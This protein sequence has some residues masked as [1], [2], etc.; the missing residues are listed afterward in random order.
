MVFVR[1]NWLIPIRKR[2]GFDF[3]SRGACWLIMPGSGCA[4][5]QVEMLIQI[6]CR[7]DSVRDVFR[8]FRFGEVKSQATTTLDFSILITGLAWLGSI[9][10]SKHPSC[11]LCRRVSVVKSSQA[12]KTKRPAARGGQAFG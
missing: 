11:S 2:W 5:Q 12:L 8:L 1:T 10:F 7:R 6:L 9:P 4:F 3:K